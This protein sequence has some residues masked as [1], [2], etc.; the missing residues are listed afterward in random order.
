M[1]QFLKQNIEK[2]LLFIALVLFVLY[3]IPQLSLA[4]FWDEVGVYGNAIFSML[5]N[6]I[7]FQPKYLEPDLSRGHPMLYVYLT[8]SFTALFGAN[9]F[10]MHLFN[11]LLS[12]IVLIS[13]FFIGSS[14]WNRKVG[15]FAGLLLVAQ[16]LFLAQSVLVL[17][18]MM[19]ALFALWSVYFFLKEQWLMYF[20]SL[21]L[22]MLT[23]ET[24]IFIPPVLGFVLFFWHLFLNRKFEIKKVLI[25]ASPLITFFA[26]LLLQKVQNGWYFFPYHNPFEGDKGFFDL[27]A[28]FTKA[29]SFFHFLFIAQSRKYSYYLGLV[30]FVFLFFTFKKS[31]QYKLIVL[32]G[33]VFGLILFSAMNHYMNRYMLLALPIT[34]LIFA[35]VFSQMAKEKIYFQYAFIGFLM[36]CTLVQIKSHKFTYDEDMGYVSVLNYHK[37]LSA[38]LEAQEDWVNHIHITANFPMNYV[39]NDTRYGFSNKD[40]SVYCYSDIR[41]AATYIVETNPGS[42]HDYKIPENYVQ[43]PFEAEGFNSVR[44]FR[45]K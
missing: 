36:I 40:I 8:A 10:A 25:V 26:F 31:S 39:F 12:I 2:I 13:V 43:I 23:K 20:L 45:K 7:G 6:G 28:I 16:P 4:L 19:L 32:L 27:A 24:A 14:L 29:K 17:P 34:S 5:D 9:V 44:I 33:I 22:A 11:L 42:W 30:V 18:E 35:Y 38:F 15:L 3:K 21:S 41:E 1:N 37:K